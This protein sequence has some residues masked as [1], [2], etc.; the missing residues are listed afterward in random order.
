LRTRNGAFFSS[1]E[2]YGVGQTFR[3]ALDRLEGQI[4]KS[5]ELASDREFVKA[6]L[7]RR[8]PLELL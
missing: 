7:K 5:T 8:F 3:A 2:G 4:V 1:S 6:Y